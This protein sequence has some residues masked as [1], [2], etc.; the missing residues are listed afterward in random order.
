MDIILHNNPTAL[1]EQSN[2]LPPSVHCNNGQPIFACVGPIRS[3]DANISECHQPNRG[4][5]LPAEYRPLA[6]MDGQVSLFR[7]YP[8]GG[9]H[10]SLHYCNVYQVVEGYS[11]RL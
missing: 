2:I 8:K 5:R 10:N 11:D 9:T 7:T 1:I 4:I 3:S 6:E